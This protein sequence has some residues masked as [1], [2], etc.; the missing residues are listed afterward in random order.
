MLLGSKIPAVIT[1]KQLV[2][3]AVTTSIITFVIIKL[4][5]SR[6]KEEK[7]YLI[8][9]GIIMCIFLILWSGAII[10]M[11][12]YSRHTYLEVVRALGGYK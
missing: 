6:V 3:F 5:S 8:I 2:A 9:Q 7:I 12:Q 11:I 4:S 10:D 1:T